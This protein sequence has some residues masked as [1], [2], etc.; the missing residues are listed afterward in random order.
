MKLL[1]VIPTLGESACLAEAVAS[2]LAL[3]P[4]WQVMLVG[5]SARAADLRR[6][7]PTCQVMT[8][9][10]P[11]LYGAINDGLRAAGDEWSWC[12]Y[13]NDDD[14]LSLAAGNIPTGQADIIYGRVDYIDE[15]G[16]KLGAFPVEPSVRRLPR[17]LAAG[18]PALTPQ[19]T[20]ISRRAFDELGG[21]DAQ[22]RFCGDFDFWLRA[23]QRGLKFAHRP[24]R[25]GTF[26]IRAGQLSA[27]RAAAAAELAGVCKKHGGGRPRFLLAAARLGFKLRHLPLIFE[28][29]RLTGYWRS[30]DLFGGRAP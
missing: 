10:G 6:A 18:V 19:G 25:V 16:R 11:G 26:R 3:G 29:R 15:T 13:L 1:I 17:L 9:S 14:T 21:F 30:R 23:A 8:E 28:R 5:P 7:F 24:E 12:S 4:A 2:A 22:L 27:Q 20:L